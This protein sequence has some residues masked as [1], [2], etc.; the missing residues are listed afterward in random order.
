L[1][2]SARVDAPWEPEVRFG[3]AMYWRALGDNDRSALELE[4]TLR[5]DP[6]HCGALHTAALYTLRRSTGT[7]AG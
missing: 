7:G 5:C 2:S 4:A 3:Y 6:S 1:L